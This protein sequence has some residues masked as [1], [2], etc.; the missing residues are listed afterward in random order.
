[1]G[2]FLSVF[3]HDGRAGLCGSHIGTVQIPCGEMF[4]N[5]EL[6]GLICASLV[7]CVGWDGE[8]QFLPQAGVL[9]RTTRSH[10]RPNVSACLVSY[11]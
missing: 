9:R 4:P 11:Y 2:S 3:R 8:H 7:W 5:Q 1:M 10:L 6:G